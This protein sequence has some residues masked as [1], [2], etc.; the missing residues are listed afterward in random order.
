MINNANQYKISAIFSPA[1]N[2]KYVIPKYQREYIWTKE[3]WEELLND[4]SESEEGHFIGSIICIKKEGID[5]LQTQELEIVDGQQRLTTISL[6]FCSIYKLLK[7]KAETKDDEFQ[8]EL[9]KYSI[10]QR[11][12]QTDFKIELSEQNNNFSDYK[13]ILAELEIIVFNRNV[14]NQG[15]RRIYKTFRYFENK[16]KDYR[17]EE[18][19]DLLLKINEIILVKIEVNSHSDAFILFESL[20]NRGVPLSATDLIKNKMLASLERVGVPIDNS[21]NRWNEIIGNLP[22]YPIQERFL[23]QFYNAFKHKKE[24]KVEGITKA[25]KSNLIKIYEMLIDKNAKFIFEELYQKSKIYSN[26]IENKNL[27]NLSNELR[28]LINVQASPAYIF[29]LYLFSSERREDKFYK[30]VLNFLVKY[31]T[32]RNLTDFPN[33]RNLDKIFTDLIEEFESNKNFSFNDVIDFFSRKDRIEKDEVFTEKLNDD[34]YENNIEMARFILSKIEETQSMTRERFT[35]FWE[36]D[37]SSKLIWT[38]EH[39]LP[40][41]ANLPPSWIDMIAQG[42]SEKAK[43]IQEKFVHKLGN[44]TLTAYNPNLSNFD[45]ITKKDRKD[46]QGKD[47]GYKNGLYL[48]K[49]LEN[50]NEWTEKDIEER[51][52][53]LVNLALEIFK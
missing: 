13:S 27:N 12:N 50:K 3:N 11:R 2:V 20:N 9:L 32:R 53:K 52:Q 40:E 24:I 17:V 35:D 22:E 37:N 7:E 39:I 34:I 30:D 18:L 1:D 47:I 49:E 43:G 26:L 25:T 38:I 33:T 19:R 31:F 8:N 23:R 4:I 10:I 45:F 28:D 44:L 16:L 21:F 29:L 5:T 14:R 15:K 6:L 41:G 51:T 48:N 36:R 46:N 42:D